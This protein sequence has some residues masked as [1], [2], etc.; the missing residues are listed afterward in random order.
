M[1]A[2]TRRICW[3][4][5]RNVSKFLLGR[6]QCGNLHGFGG[7]LTFDGTV[8][9]EHGR[10]SGFVETEIESRRAGIGVA[11]D[12]DPVRIDRTYEVLKRCAGDELE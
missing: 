4:T 3:Y 7:C 5:S 9:V 10:D 11:T 6:K 2:L 12:P 1:L 8:E